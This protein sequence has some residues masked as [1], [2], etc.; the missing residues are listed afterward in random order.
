MKFPLPLLVFL[1]TPLAH[2]EPKDPKAKL[3][4]EAALAYTASVNLAA[5]SA[6]LTQNQKDVDSMI[7][8]RTDAIVARERAAAAARNRVAHEFDVYNMTRSSGLVNNLKAMIHSGDRADAE[9]GELDAMEAALRADVKAN[10][11]LPTL[12]TEKIDEAAKKLAVLA[13]ERSS[14]ERA[15]D[16]IAFFKA[17]KKEVKKL[18]AAARDA[19]NKADAATKPALVPTIK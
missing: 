12:S 10:A 14:K 17:T 15:E 11:A 19:R 5:V 6:M 3:S 1:V 8:A 13:E 2:A 7:A 9:P 18:E 16:A 4:D